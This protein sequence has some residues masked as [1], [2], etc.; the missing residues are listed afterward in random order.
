MTSMIVC[1]FN[2]R[3]NAESARVRLREHGF[4]DARIRI[5]DGGL[6]QGSITDRHA[7]DPASARSVDRGLV[8]VFERI[9]GAVRLNSDEVDSY[10]HAVYNGK[11]VLALHVADD[12]AAARAASI[13][14]EF[15]G[16]NIAPTGCNDGMSPALTFTGGNENGRWGQST[17][18]NVEVAVSGPRIYPLPNSATGWGEASHGSKSSIGG[19]M[20][21]PGRPNGLLRDTEGLGTDADRRILE[22]SNDT[23]PR[24]QA[25]T[26]CGMIVNTADQPYRVATD[27]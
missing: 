26:P 9:F 4:E 17:G 22:G 13:L 1:V 12:A 6:A 24:Q 11:S 23:V 8:G 27:R 7:K 2:S 19:T 20:N 5:E 10:A 15:S 21:D 16:E 18:V 25:P 14:K 3:N